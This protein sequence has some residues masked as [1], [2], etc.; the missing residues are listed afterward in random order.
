M[1]LL[2]CFE[3]VAPGSKPKPPESEVTP[4]VSTW[5]IENE[6]GKTTPERKNLGVG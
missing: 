6:R 5:N 3:I 4:S 2:K 1:F